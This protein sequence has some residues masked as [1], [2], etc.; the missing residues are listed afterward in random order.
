MNES[1]VPERSLQQRMNALERAN[2]VRTYR[3]DLKRDIK[4]GRKDVVGV[5]RDLPE[6]I[7]T[8]KLFDLM[9]AV[10]KFGRTK[11]NRIFVQCRISPSKTVGGISERQ[12]G[13]VISYLRRR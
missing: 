12:L 4:A 7:E 1:H 8:M 13:E 2:K 3:A 10:P 9:L 6:Q 11:V 5:L